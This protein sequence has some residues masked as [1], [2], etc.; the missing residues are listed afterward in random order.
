MQSID[1]KE[2]FSVKYYNCW[3]YGLSVKVEGPAFLA[4]PCFYHTGLAITKHSIILNFYL[5]MG[6]GLR[7]F[8]R[9]WA[10]DKDFAGESSG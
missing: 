7:V 4:G 8:G 3:G 2:A 1:S 5:L 9:V 6:V 10:L